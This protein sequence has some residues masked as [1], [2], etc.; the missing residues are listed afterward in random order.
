P[1]SHW[2]IVYFFFFRKTLRDLSIAVDT[3][4][5]PMPQVGSVVTS[6]QKRAIDEANCKI[7]AIQQTRPG[8]ARSFIGQMMRQ[9]DADRLAELCMKS[10]GY[11]ISPNDTQSEQKEEQ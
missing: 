2:H 4:T 6:E 3:L 10:K 8:N 1:N 7:A 9:S 11:K 5:R